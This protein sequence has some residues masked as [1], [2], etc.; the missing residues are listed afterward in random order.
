MACRDTSQPVSE[1]WE[2]S[3]SPVFWTLISSVLFLLFESLFTLVFTYCA[4]RLMHQN[5]LAMLSHHKALREL[6]RTTFNTWPP[7]IFCIISIN[8]A[9][10]LSRM[11]SN[12]LLGL[13]VESRRWPTDSAIDNNWM[14]TQVGWQSPS[15]LLSLTFLIQWSN[16]TLSVGLWTPSSATS[17]SGNTFTTAA[18]KHTLKATGC[19][20]RHI[21]WAQVK[22]PFSSQIFFCA[23]KNLK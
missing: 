19:L 21:V 14:D 4:V 8:P 20:E 1:S 7:A 10:S 11:S 13:L 5:Y 17:H 3:L 16:I 6:C 23:H 12:C 2:M 18:F 22:K 9:L 15:L